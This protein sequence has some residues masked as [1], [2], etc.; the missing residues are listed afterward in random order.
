[1]FDENK[2]LNYLKENNKLPSE[3]S[4]LM[5]YSS[6]NSIINDDLREYKI[7]NIGTK[8]NFNYFHNSG[9][10][11]SY[12]WEE[13]LGL[14]YY[15]FGYGAGDGGIKIYIE[16]IVEL[17]KN[18]SSPNKD[19]SQPKRDNNRIDCSGFGNQN[20][21]NKVRDNFTNSGKQILGEEYLNNGQFG[22]SFLDPS[23]GQ[24][25]NSKVSTD[26]NCNIINVQV[27]IMR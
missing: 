4:T 16:N 7:S 15:S 10:Y 22:I 21:I 9:H 20:C 12:T 1:M 13:G 14:T 25:F 6:T 26:C 24:T 27:S 2:Y 3:D 19:N 18:K 5:I 11:S 23:I 8:C 17:N